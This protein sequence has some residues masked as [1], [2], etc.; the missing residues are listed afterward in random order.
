MLPPTS[1]DDEKKE[2]EE[3]EDE[4]DGGAP[5]QAAYKPRTTR[6]GRICKS[7]FGKGDAE[8]L[9][10]LRRDA[11]ARIDLRHAR[12]EAFRFAIGET[13]HLSLPSE[14]DEDENEDEED[15][16]EDGDDLEDEDDDDEDDDE[17]DDDEDDEDDDDEDGD[18]EAVHTHRQLDAEREQHVMRLLAARFQ[19]DRSQ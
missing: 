3:D 4:H 17:E 14:R 10:R 8:E 7:G 12:E 15:E 11:L 16:G 9:K 5:V 2:N 19:K 6:V 1:D 18:E 13:N